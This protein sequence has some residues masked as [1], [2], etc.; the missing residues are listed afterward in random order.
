MELLRSEVSKEK[1]SK[2]TDAI[3]QMSKILISFIERSKARN[4][5][6]DEININ[7]HRLLSN[8]EGRPIVEDI[9][10]SY[11]DSRVGSTYLQNGNF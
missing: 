3:G 2:F 10:Q 11:E 6:M 7:T 9:R 8:L 5:H 4:R 1:Y